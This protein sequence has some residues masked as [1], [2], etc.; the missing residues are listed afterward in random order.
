MKNILIFMLCLIVICSGTVCGQ[1]D[2]NDQTHWRVIFDIDD[3]DIYKMNPLMLVLYNK[4][5][6]EQIERN[7]PCDV[8]S[9]G[10]RE[11]GK[12]PEGVVYVKVEGEIKFLKGTDYDGGAVSV[13][14]TR[15]KVGDPYRL[16]FIVKAKGSSSSLRWVD[17]NVVKSANDLEVDKWE[18]I[19]G[20]Y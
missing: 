11:I 7:K 5:D 20:G 18:T 10:G 8:Y 6:L 2:V 9:E 14:S 17:K 16:L 12:C 1:E 3:V 13:T 15:H 19:M 4:E